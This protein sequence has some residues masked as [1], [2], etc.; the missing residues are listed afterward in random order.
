METTNIFNGGKEETLARKPSHS[1][2]QYYKSR[3]SASTGLILRK[4]RELRIREMVKKMEYH[5]KSWWRSLQKNNYLV[6][7]LGVSVLLVG[8]AFRLLYNRSSDFPPVP[9]APFLENTQ[10]SATPVISLDFQQNTD[11]ISAQGQI[12]FSIYCSLYLLVEIIW[13]WNG[14]CSVLL[15]TPLI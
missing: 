4:E 13:S 12:F 9:G 8:L 3:Y 11:Q 5:W 14:I 15:P 7:K 6:I 1:G 2:N 10:I